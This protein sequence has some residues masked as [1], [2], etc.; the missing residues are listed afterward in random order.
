[1]SWC[2]RG[3][4]G[5]SLDKAEDNDEDKE[6]S[7]ALTK[8]IDI[9]SV[10]VL[11]L[12]P[13]LFLVSVTPLVI[14]AESLLTPETTPNNIIASYVLYRQRRSKFRENLLNVSEGSSSSSSESSEKP[15]LEP[16]AWKAHTASCKL[17]MEEDT[18]RRTSILN[19]QQDS[20][21]PG[22]FNLRERAEDRMSKSVIRLQYAA[23]GPSNA[24][25]QR[26]NAVRCRYSRQSVLSNWSSDGFSLGEKRQALN[27]L[28][29]GTSHF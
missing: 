8:W 10:Q 24:G 20:K 14:M 2:G 6:T 26:R 11:F 28:R 17:C 21:P 27:G 19:A 1:M 7:M 25:L 13:V 3:Q 16:E 15:A 23:F 4:R 22:S 18:I 29:P 12:V 5:S 9:F